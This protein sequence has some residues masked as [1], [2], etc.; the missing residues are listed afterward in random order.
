MRRSCGSDAPATIAFVDFGLCEELDETVRKRQMQYLSALYRADTDQVFRFLREILIPTE[1][2]EPES[3]RRDFVTAARAW[4]AE[5]RGNTEG[6]P[7]DTAYSSPAATYMI[8]VMRAARR[9]GYQVPVAILAMYRALLAAESVARQLSSHAD[10]RSV[11]REF[12]EQLQSDKVLRVLTSENFNPRLFNY[13]SFWRDYPTLLN[14]TL[15]YRADNRFVLNVNVSENADLKHDR[16][17][18][19]RAVVASIVAVSLAVLLGSLEI[20]TQTSSWITWILAAAL[21]LLYMIVYLN[22]RR[23]K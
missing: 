21:L 3:L 14:Q 18:R 12:F 5:T 7:L 17:R 11:G 15:T 16:N 1:R 8:A 9:N 2:A 22:Y 10:L 4:T 19:A 20:F 13:M 6:R 23:L